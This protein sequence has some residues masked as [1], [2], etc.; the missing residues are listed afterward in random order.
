METLQMMSFENT[1]VTSWNFSKIKEELQYQLNNYVGLVYTDDNIKDA[2]N[3]RATLN[4][5][6]KAISDAEKAYK[7]KCLIPYE[8]IKPQIKELINLIEEQRILIDSTVKDYESRQK[9][10]KEQNV[11]Q[12]YERKAVVL[13]TMAEPLYE[14]LFDSKWTNAST[15]KVKYEEAIQIAINKAKEDIDAIKSWN[16]P[17]EETLLEVYLINLS[18]EKTKEKNFELVE[19]AKKAGLTNEPKQTTAATSSNEKQIKA[20]VENGVAMKLY[21]SQ[22]QL[23][24]I[25]DFM[26]AIGVEYELL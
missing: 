6:K 23:N 9:M 4:K 5:V 13:G 2:K 21:A 22:S 3:D 12:Y 1:E 26:K 19:S 11:H 16:S 10:E 25:F 20:D 18:L 24:Q 14:K 15:S 17:F 8:A 7:E